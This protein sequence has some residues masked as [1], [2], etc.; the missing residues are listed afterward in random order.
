MA[1]ENHWRAPRIAKELAR[2]GIDVHEDTVRRYM[3][4]RRPTEA[5]RQSWRSFLANHRDI[6]A[7][8]DFLVVP[9]ATFRVLYGFFV[10]HHGR[11]LVL[12]FNATMHPT[13]AWVIQQLRE[14]FPFDESA[15]YLIKRQRPH[16][17]RS[18][19]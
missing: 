16:L 7:A 4:K 17:Q 15:G 9:T 8:M 2:L 14:A 6:I 5:Q 10:I 19:S 3:P 1:R 11:R 18:G 12:H 13:A